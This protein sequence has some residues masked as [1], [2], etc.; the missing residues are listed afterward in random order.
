MLDQIEDASGPRMADMTLAVVRKVMNWHASRSDD[1]ASPIVKGMRPPRGKGR[2][3]TLSDDEIRA[4]WFAPEGIHP[5]EIVFARLVKFILLTAT[6]RNE[7]AHARW[8]EIKGSDWLI[9]GD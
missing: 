2:E 5:S 3:R 7:A 6:R 1:F 9:P 8:A 4:I